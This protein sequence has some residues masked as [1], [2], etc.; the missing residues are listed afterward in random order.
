MKLLV[1]LSI[2]EYEQQVEKL[3]DKAGLNRFSVTNITGY[4]KDKK[5]KDF[6]WFGNCMGCAKTNSIL[7]FSFSPEEVV[8]QAIVEINNYNEQEKD[9][10]PL[11]AFVMDVESFSRV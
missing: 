9:P 1:V 3:L 6:S 10:F 11:H 2:K 5:K 4:K 7:I 8:N